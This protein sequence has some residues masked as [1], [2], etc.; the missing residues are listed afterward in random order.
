MARYIKRKT[1]CY[2]FLDTGPVSLF[3][4]PDLL[5]SSLEHDR[6]MSGT[7]IRANLCLTTVPWSG[8]IAIT[9]SC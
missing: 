6:H 3:N 4:I 8:V 2:A 5:G 9:T 1:H 7:W